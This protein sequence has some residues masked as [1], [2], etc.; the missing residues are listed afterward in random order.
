[1]IPQ[2]QLKQ[3]RSKLGSASAKLK[4]FSTT[5]I[6]AE[7]RKRKLKADNDLRSSLGMSKK[8]RKKRKATRI[9]HNHQ[10]KAADDGVHYPPN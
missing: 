2:E 5:Q 3:L 7:L 1:M 4:E 8:A 9:K 10:S 6:A